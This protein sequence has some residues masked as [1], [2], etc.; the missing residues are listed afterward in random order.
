MSGRRLLEIVA[1]AYIVQAAAAFAI[2]F[3]LP[4]FAVFRGV[5]SVWEASK[6]KGRLREALSHAP[7]VGVLA[8]P[9]QSVRPPSSPATGC[10]LKATVQGP[11]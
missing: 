4:I 7:R 11:R 9:L 8:A 5:V 1:V 2:G 6:Q 3:T 10:S